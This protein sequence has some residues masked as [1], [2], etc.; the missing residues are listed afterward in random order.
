MH[1]DSKN[2]ILLQTAKGYVSSSTTPDRISVARLILDSG[3]KHS[4][5]S[6]RLW[7]ELKLPTLSQQT[8]TIKVFGDEEGTLRTCDVVQFCIRSPYSELS[9]Y[10]TAF[11]VPTLCAP[12]SDQAINF[13]ASNYSHLAGIWL[14][15]FPAER[16]EHLNCDILIGANYY[17]NFMTGKC[18]KGESGPVAL[19]SSLGWILSGPVHIDVESSPIKI[20]QTHVLKV[21]TDI[22]ASEISLN[23]QLSKF[24]DLESI[25]I[26][27][28]EATV[29][30]S[31]QDEIRFVDSRYQ[32]KLPWKPEHA[33]L[34][35]NYTLSKKRLVSNLSKLKTDPNL[36]NEYNNI[37]KEQESRGIIERV[38]ILQSQDCTVGKT[39]YLPHYSIIRQD[40]STTKVRVVYDAS[41]KD[42]AGTSLN[43]FL[44]TGPCLLKTVAEI[45]ARFRLYP[46]AVIFCRPIH[47][48]DTSFT[49]IFE[50][51]TQLN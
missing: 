19:E 51:K 35:D 3:S 23:T 32:V 50:S 31:F 46:I 21:D 9:V 49:F 6:E 42:K 48:E 2:T 41:A 8:L 7:D 1:V 13:A 36:L 10:V 34:P 5:I 25:G 17:W 37:I 30:K 43:S 39:T 20:V 33:T 29:Y 38:D 12:L 15:D 47:I 28:D 22:N 18:I 45:V 16:H 11:V 40:K 27:K 14:A 24:W 26:R 4:Y 44:Y